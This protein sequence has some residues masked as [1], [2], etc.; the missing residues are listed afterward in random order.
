MS[1]L[2]YLSQTKLDELRASIA[3]NTDRYKGTGFSDL[4]REPGWSIA[5]S[6]E[7]DLAGLGDLDGSDNRSE[8]DLKNSRIVGR[9]LAKLTPSLANEERIWARLSHVEGFEYSRSRW[10]RHGA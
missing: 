3:G 8:T 7:I 9:V 5:L 6:E 2:A 10:L 4:T 1:H